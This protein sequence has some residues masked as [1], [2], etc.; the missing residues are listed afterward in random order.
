MATR[1]KAKQAFYGTTDIAAILGVSDTK[2]R[3]LMYMFGRNG[4]LLRCGKLLRVP[5][6]DFDAY[7]RQNTCGDLAQR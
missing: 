1:Q 5:I 3:Q 2:A 7:I 6:K 4:K